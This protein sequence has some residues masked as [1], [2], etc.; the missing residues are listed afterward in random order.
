MTTYIINNPQSRE[1]VKDVIAALSRGERVKITGLAFIEIVNRKARQGINPKTL[2]KI[3]I[4]A[5]KKIRVRATTTLKNA[6][7]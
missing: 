3:A 2:E 1:L 4:P 5:G 7:I 6:I